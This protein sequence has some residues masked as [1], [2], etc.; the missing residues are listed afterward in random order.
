VAGARSPVYIAAVPILTL[1]AAATLSCIAVDGD[2]LRC[3]AERV[4]LTGIDAPE[5]PGHCQPWRRCVAGD[6]Q[7]SKA[8]LARLI[9][10]RF[11]SIERL[12]QDRYGRTLALAHAGG[13]NLACAQLAAGRAVYVERWDSGGRLRGCR[14]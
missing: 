3:G 11:V 2:T 4:R 1:V 5:L 13:V 14:R 7:A 6:S 12:G 9:A 10:G 8:A